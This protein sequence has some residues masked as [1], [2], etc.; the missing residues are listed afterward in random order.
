MAWKIEFD[1]AAEKEFSK[2][3]SMV[4]GEIITY[5]DKLMQLKS[6]RLRGKALSGDKSGLWRYRT[7]KY[8]LICKIEEHRFVVFVIRVGKRDKVYE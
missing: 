2:L 3:G 7:G 1:P 8:R 5:L 6:P 4:Q